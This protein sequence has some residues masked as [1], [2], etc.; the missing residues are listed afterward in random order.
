MSSKFVPLEEAAQ[1]LGISTDKLVAMRSGGEVRGFK[2]GASWKFPQTEIDRLL[3]E[4]VDNEGDEYAGFGGGDSDDALASDD[5]W[6]QEPEGSATL[7]PEQG[8]GSGSRII[9]GSGSDDDDLIL[10]DEPSDL[11]LSIG[12]DVHNAQ[13]ELALASDNDNRSS[14]ESDLELA[15]ELS[16]TPASRRQASPLS[17]V[18]SDSAITTPKVSIDDGDELRLLDDSDPDLGLDDLAKG[19]LDS[20]NDVL[21]DLNLGAASQDGSDSLIHGDSTPSGLSG[22]GALGSDLK[23]PL[24]DLSGLDDALSNDDELMIASDDDDIVLDELGSGSGILESGIDLMQPSDSGLSLESEPIEL[25]GSG[26]SALDLGADIST[27][28]TPGSS[29]HG[30]DASPWGSDV[31]PA[32]GSGS[33]VDFKADEEFQLSP[34][35]IGLEVDDDSASQVIDIEH[36]D[37]FGGGMLDD[38]ALIDPS[39]GDGR[40]WAQRNELLADDAE[41]IDDASLVEDMVQAPITETAPTARTKTL[42]P[43]ASVPFSVWNVV[44]LASILLLLSIGGML[45]TDLIRNLWTYSEPVSP[46]HSLSETVL[47]AIGMNG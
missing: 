41:G 16:Q 30:S 6:Q 23:S 2:D 39:Q 22:A 28:N 1:L 9:G 8:A 37:A 3:A 26:I 25:A 12:S 36:S 27:G 24:S 47:S 33:L 34:S 20:S 13:D 18:S 11:E 43:S 19:M 10:D 15:D 4:G 29:P 32:D 38:E 17:P 44:S 45:A 35:G 42:P 31:S 40:G 5:D 14:G 46:I 21:S 7:V